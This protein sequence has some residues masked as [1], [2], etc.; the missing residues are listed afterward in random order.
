MGVRVGRAENAGRVERLRRMRSVN[1]P[2]A[3]LLEGN[4]FQCVCGRLNNH[5]SMLMYALSVASVVRWFHSGNS[6]KRAV[7]Y[8]EHTNA[9][10]SILHLEF[11]DLFEDLDLAN[12]LC[13]A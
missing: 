1:R 7:H 2:F 11:P 8:I 4:S 3:G 10:L 6:N 9:T 12:Y 5:H 13:S